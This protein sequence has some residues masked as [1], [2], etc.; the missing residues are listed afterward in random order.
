MFDGVGRGCGE[1]IL[2]LMQASRKIILVG[3]APLCS[4]NL[5]DNAFPSRFEMV[6]ALNAC[7]PYGGLEI[8]EVHLSRIV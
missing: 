7:R 1:C 2:P 6:I 5:D 8:V 3:T 4:I